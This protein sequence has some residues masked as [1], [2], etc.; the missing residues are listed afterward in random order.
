MNLP[1]DII[2]IIF[3][4]KY[5]FE[6]TEIKQKVLNEIKKIKMYNIGMCLHC[7]NV[8]II[9]LNNEEDIYAGGE[10]NHYFYLVKS[11]YYLHELKIFKYG[12]FDFYCRLCN[13]YDGFY[14]HIQH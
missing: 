11:I 12:I 7:R 3:D 14:S 4:Y 8:I 6:H 13:R 9:D 5:K 10:C 1:Q 2:N